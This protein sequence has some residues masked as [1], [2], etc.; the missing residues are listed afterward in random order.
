MEDVINNNNTVQQDLKKIQMK[1]SDA[2]YLDQGCWKDTRDRS[3]KNSLEGKSGCNLDDRYKDRK[4][5]IVK[6]YECARKYGF[7]IFAVQ[8]SG[9]CWAGGDDDSYRKYGRSTSCGRNGEGGAW[10][11]H[12]YKIV[13][14]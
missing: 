12:V 1:D 2:N 5:P 6:C 9:E 4:H 11:N 7:V 14:V 3:L 10:A 13:G 8:H